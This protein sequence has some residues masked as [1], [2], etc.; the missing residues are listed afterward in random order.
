MSRADMLELHARE[1]AQMP[2]TWAAFRFE[3]F[4]HVPD[5]RGNLYYEIEG[6][7]APMKTKG[8]G[9]GQPNWKQMDKSTRKTVTILVSEQEAWE[10]RW[11]QTTGRCRKCM[12]TAQVF[13]RWAKGEGA[14]YKPCE[15]C[16]GTGRAQAGD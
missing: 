3:C 16:I 5:K 1:L 11:E 15:A 10:I 6:A 14:T 12:G 7:V 8:I 4:P 13:A 9:A 2:E